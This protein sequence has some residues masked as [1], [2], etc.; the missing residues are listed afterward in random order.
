MVLYRTVDVWSVA[1]T[2]CGIDFVIIIPLN[3]VDMKGHSG[4]YRGY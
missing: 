4:N 3:V 2:S 1:Q